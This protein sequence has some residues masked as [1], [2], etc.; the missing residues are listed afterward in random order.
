MYTLYNFTC[1]VYL[2][3]MNPFKQKSSMILSILQHVEILFYLLTSHK[4][5]T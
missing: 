4:R 3:H 5:N 2:I 1:I